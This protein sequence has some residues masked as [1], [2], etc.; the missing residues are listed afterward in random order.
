MAGDALQPGGVLSQTV[1]TLGQTVQTTVGTTGQ[2][3]ERTLDSSGAVVNQ[4]TVGD[5]LDTARSGFEVVG[6]STDSEGRTV[7]RLRNEAGVVV[8]AVLDEAGRVVSTRT[9]GG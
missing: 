5:I 7:R 9:V 8:E 6:E 1:N 3:V 2:I 4:R